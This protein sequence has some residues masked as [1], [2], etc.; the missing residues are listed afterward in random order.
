[1]DDPKC[2]PWIAL[3]T[4][5]RDRLGLDDLWPPHPEGW[6]TDLVYDLIE[7]VHDLVA[8]PRSRFYHSYN[9]CGFHYSDFALA[10]GRSLYRWRVNQLLDR[11][12][13]GL[14]LASEGEDTGRLVHA[15]GDDRDEL[16][17]RT[18]VSP[19]PRDRA[20]IH[21]AVALF[22]S[23]GATRDD[24]RSAVAALARVLEARRRL[25]E[26]E[27]LSKDEG[28]LFEI[29]NKFDVR[30]RNA[31]QR[32]DYDEAYLDWIFWWYLATVEL[33]DQLRARPA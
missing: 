4:E 12:G 9:R 22:R 14:Q 18:L 20:A 13:I 32:P 10:P 26:A 30:H 11:H 8:R 25:L 24:K 5:T 16:V 1:V 17:R 2:S 6:D 23:R 3:N 29:A 21:H 28:A 15:A 7:V 27:L 19:D 33:T 31:N